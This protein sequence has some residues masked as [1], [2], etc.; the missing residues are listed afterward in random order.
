MALLIV[1]HLIL[2]QKLQNEVGAAIC[3]QRETPFKCSV[4]IDRCMVFRLRTRGRTMCAPTANQM[5]FC[6]N[7]NHRAA[8]QQQRQ[9]RY[10]TDKKETLPKQR[11]F[12]SQR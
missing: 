1:L 11:H 7:L 5:V 3:R 2:L 6:N 9:W 10:I 12:L 4:S 8:I